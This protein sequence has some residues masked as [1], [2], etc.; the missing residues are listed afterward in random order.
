MV[1]IAERVKTAVQWL[2]GFVILLLVIAKT[3]LMMGKVMKADWIEYL[4]PLDSFGILELVGGALGFS[5]AMDLAY[6]CIHRNLTKP[7]NL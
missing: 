2:I 5:A 6:I 1:Q 7:F 4:T 3:V